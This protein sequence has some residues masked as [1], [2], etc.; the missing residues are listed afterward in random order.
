MIAGFA[1]KN[2]LKDLVNFLRQEPPR[3]GR[4]IPDLLGQFL[5]AFSSAY[6][7]SFGPPFLSK[8]FPVFLY[9]RQGPKHSDAS[10]YRQNC[11]AV[12]RCA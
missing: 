6:G 12:C 3:F 7:F 5:T 8:G 11:R 9:L 10:F 4:R 1:V 2:L